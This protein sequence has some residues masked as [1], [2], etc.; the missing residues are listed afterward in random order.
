[1]S[2][3]KSVGANSKPTEKK[4]AAVEKKTKKARMNH[5]DVIMQSI[6]ELGDRAILQR[7]EERGQILKK[8]V[9]GKYERISSQEYVVKDGIVKPQLSEEGYRRAVV[10][11][12]KSGRWM[13]SN[14]FQDQVQQKAK[15]L[16]LEIKAQ[17][18]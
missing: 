6:K 8:A 11:Y 9:K 13:I 14:Q 18:K 16:K 5:H 1:M 3:Q 10:F 15:E 12:N 4:L 2:A 17:K 7:I